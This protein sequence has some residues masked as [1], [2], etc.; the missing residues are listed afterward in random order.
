MRLQNITV[1]SAIPEDKAA[2]LHFCQHTW[3]NSDD[4]IADVWDQWMADPAGQI[5]VAELAGQ[6]VAM[7]RVVQLS[8]Q[9]G[10]WEALRVDPQYRGR[11]LVR[12]LDPEIDQY[13]QARNISTIRCCVASWNTAMP[14]I[15]QRRGYQP[16]ACYVEHSAPAIE[17][18]LCQL[19]QLKEGDREA[20]WR[21]IQ[22]R[23]EARPLFVCRGAKWQTLTIEQ[24]QQRLQRG[25]IWGYR[26]D[27]GLQGLLIQSHL[28]SA[29]S[30]LWV[31]YME[32]TTQGLPGLLNEMRHLASQLK[33]SRV[34]GFFPK[35]KDLLAVLK[36]M[37]YEA[38]PGDEFW[39][40]EK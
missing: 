27:R 31:G 3:P 37:G 25:K 39:V 15:I 36:Q 12:C 9:E 19:G 18:R 23:Q 14:D 16:V 5:L 33:Y 24:V 20:V 7:T 32:A 8:E 26:H 34:S 10:W 4:Y 6:P 11:G 35:R 17:S 1:R 40:Y 21:M 29:D 28:E 13:F 2:V 30:V 38:S 22:Q